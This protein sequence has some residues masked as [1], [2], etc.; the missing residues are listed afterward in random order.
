MAR[1]CDIC[2]E[3]DATLRVRQVDKAGA[4]DIEICAECAKVRG[5][6]EARKISTSVAEI[7]AGMKRD[8]AEGDEAI[9]CPGCGMTFA[10]FKRKGRLGC[11]RCYPAFDDKLRP[12]IRRIQGAVQHV[13]RAAKAGRRRARDQMALVRLRAELEA[14]IAAED[15]EQAARLRDELGKAE[16]NARR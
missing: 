6:T 8:V 12:L 13:G 10:E 3:R 15:Y 11:A 9:V 1:K 7:M 5:F 16:K 4:A 14:A 2:G